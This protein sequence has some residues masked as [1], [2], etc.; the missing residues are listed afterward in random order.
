MEPYRKR[1]DWLRR[2]NQF[3]PATGDPRHVV[4][5]DPAEMLAT[6][7]AST[8]LETIGDAHWLETYERRLRSVDQESQANLLGRLLARA[9]TIRLLQTR[10]RLQ[11]AWARTPAIL[12]P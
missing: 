6:A 4:P 8:G 2:L 10:L 3:G 12:E 11:D 5:L 1:P 7:R 9:E